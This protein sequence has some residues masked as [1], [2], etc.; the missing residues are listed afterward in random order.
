MINSFFLSLR[1]K[2][3]WEDQ[4]TIVEATF[5]KGRTDENLAKMH[6]RCKKPKL[7]RL[8]WFFL[9]LSEAG[10]VCRADDDDSAN[11]GRY[12]YLQTNTFFPQDKSGPKTHSLPDCNMFLSP[13][14]F[15]IS[16]HKHWM[17]RQK[18]KTKST[19]WKTYKYGLKFH[20]YRLDWS[21]FQIALCISF[22]KVGVIRWCVVSCG[23][24]TIPFLFQEKVKRN[25]SN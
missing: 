14:S 7:E 15:I 1:L 20:I 16:N 6:R 18:T 22:G 8:E 19:Y 17:L 25:K 13:T 10:T 5:I 11:T 24:K 3:K 4:V 23:R 2:E 21:L 9:V 12:V